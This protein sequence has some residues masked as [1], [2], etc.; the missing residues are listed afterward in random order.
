MA[1]RKKAAKDTSIE[2]ATNA[3]GQDQSPLIYTDRV[4]MAVQYYDIKLKLQQI[5]RADED[6]VVLREAAIVVFS[7]PHAK[8]LIE[9]LERGLK[10]YE[11]RFGKIASP[12]DALVKVQEE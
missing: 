2:R 11:D 6:E 10:S 3:I 9:I 5:V 8:A 7:P 4:E 12:P 1:A